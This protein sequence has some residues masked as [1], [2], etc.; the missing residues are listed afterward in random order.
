MTFGNAIVNKN[1]E[2][3]SKSDVE[4]LSVSAS[5]LLKIDRFLW[6]TVTNKKE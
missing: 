1:M 2:N 6:Y 4:M 3:L 5:F